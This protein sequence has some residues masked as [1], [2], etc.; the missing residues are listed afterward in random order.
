MTEDYSHFS[1]DVDLLKIA[2]GRIIHGSRNIDRILGQ[3][4]SAEQE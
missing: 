1:L 4:S 3:E 2:I